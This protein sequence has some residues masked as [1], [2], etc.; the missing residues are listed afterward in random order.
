MAKL[1]YVRCGEMI[2]KI[3]FVSAFN[4][5]SIFRRLNPAAARI[6]LSVPQ[7]PGCG[8]LLSCVSSLQ[9]LSSCAADGYGNAGQSIIVFYQKLN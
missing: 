6:V 9:G 1:G 4:L 7:N 2:S 8:L 5:R 3:F